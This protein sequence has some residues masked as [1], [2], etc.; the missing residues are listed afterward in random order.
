MRL[1][2]QIKDVELIRKE[3]YAELKAIQEEYSAE[4]KFSHIIK[5]INQLD[6]T[7]PLDQLRRFIYTMCALVHHIQYG[8]LQES[9]VKNLLELAS[10]LLSFNGI[11]PSRSKLSVLHG[12]LRMVR[13]QIF[14]NQGEFWPSV[15]N[16][17][18]A[19]E[20]SG[21]ELPGGEPYQ[22]SLLGIKCF[23]LG[24]SH[25]AHEYFMKVENALTSGRLFEQARI[26]RIKAL[27]L[28]NDN[29][30]FLELLHSSLALADI[31]EAFQ[32][33]LA[34]EKACFEAQ[35]AKDLEPLYQLVYE[36]KSHYEASYIIELLFWAWCFPN[37]RWMHRLPKLR[38]IS[39]RPEL[40]L[41]K[42]GHFYRAAQI[43]DQAYD[44]KLNHIAKLEKI[45]HLFKLVDRV[46]NVDKELFLWLAL[47]RWLE[48]EKHGTYHRLA[49]ERYRHVCL[50]LSNGK[51][52]DVLGFLD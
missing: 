7:D 44:E 33:E 42:M 16:Q 1:R 35:Q 21:S 18:I 28:A 4:V 20:V 27:R 14:L 46:R 43:L 49:L 31:S 30:S 10:G 50:A 40:D 32:L 17:L 22:A 29:E 23:R 8:G 37:Y 52:Q 34:W 9:E 26:S 48:R 5:R 41:K 6:S 38:T 24:F 19:E 3:I 47:A 2:W 12:E 51:S 11:Q 13:S 39:R 45:E 25:L 15:W 36:Q